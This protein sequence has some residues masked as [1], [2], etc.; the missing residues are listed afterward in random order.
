VSTLQALYAGAVVGIAFAV[1]WQ[2]V[3]A[4]DARIQNIEYGRIASALDKADK[5]GAASPAPRAEG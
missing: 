2:R 5:V 1:L 4:L 3:D